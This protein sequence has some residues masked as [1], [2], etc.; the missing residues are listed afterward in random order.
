MDRPINLCFAEASLHID[1]CVCSQTGTRN[2]WQAWKQRHSPCNASVIKRKTLVAFKAAIAHVIVH[3]SKTVAKS[4]GNFT[5]WKCW[6]L[7]W[8]L[9]R[10]LDFISPWVCFVY[11]LRRIVGPRYSN[12][13]I[14]HEI[15][16]LKWYLTDTSCSLEI[17]RGSN[18]R[19][20]ILLKP[21]RYVAYREKLCRQKVHYGENCT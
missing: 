8:C 1:V 6:D 10:F 16:V 7:S 18:A 13:L 5:A 21:P 15:D 4:S 9:V 14:L 12:K 20:D 3:A 19:S 11:T 17:G 2:G